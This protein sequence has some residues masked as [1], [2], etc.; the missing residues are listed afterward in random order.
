LVVSFLWTVNSLSRLLAGT[1]ALQK[2]ARWSFWV[3]QH[4]LGCD[5]Y[6][7]AFAHIYM[8]HGE[9]YPVFNILSKADDGEK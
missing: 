8:T 2:L 1:G 9:G 5:Q 3:T 7:E 6:W 4:L